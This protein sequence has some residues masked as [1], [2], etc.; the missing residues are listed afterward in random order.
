MNKNI[1]L[2]LTTGLLFGVSTSIQA[3][4]DSNFPEIISEFTTKYNKHNKNRAAN[5][6][7]AAGKIDG[8]ILY[9]G[10]IFSFNKH[11]GKRTTAKGYKK[12]PIFSRGIRKM[13]TG[14]GICQVS[15]TLWN[16]AIRAD[17][18][19][20]Q[21]RNHSMLVNY[22]PKGL[23][24][25][26]SY[27]SVDLKFQNTLERPIKIAVVNIPG[28][29]TFKI[30]GHKTP[31]KEVKVKHHTIKLWGRGTR[32]VVDKNLRPGTK[33]VKQ[34]GSKGGRAI[35]TR[36]VYMNGQL[37]KKDTWRSY[38]KG[39]IRTIVHNPLPK[40]KKRAMSSLIL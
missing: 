20:I 35:A 40:L 28:K 2:V 22:L 8:K 11:L 21:R 5:I 10:E 19:S 18:K 16:A 3:N 17:L 27:G 12:A 38:Y 13:G 34:K 4:T 24:A 26:V 14:G 9:P 32:Y 15:G 7:I 37:V 36:E 6:Q 1:Q 23:D 30:L 33:K 31:G 25:A 29:L 39:G